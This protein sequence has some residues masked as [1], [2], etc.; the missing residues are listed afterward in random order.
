MKYR[1]TIICIF[2]LIC[3]GHVDVFTQ[4]PYDAIH[5]DVKEE[6]I[7]NRRFKHSLVEKLIK[8]LP[9]DRFTV[10]SLGSSI[11]GKTIYQVKVGE[12]PIKV[13]LWSQMHGNEPT[14]T[15]ALF[16]IFNYLADSSLWL[17]QDKDLLNK[18]TLYF[19]PMLNPDGAD[20]FERR[21]ALPVDLNRDALRLQ[22]PE[23]RI[24]K[25]ANDR[26]DPM[27]GFNL[28][29]QNRYTSAGK[30]GNT[31]SM[32]FLAPAEDEEQSWGERRTA[33][34]Q[35]IVAIN[36][37]LQYYLPNQVGRYSAEFEPR[38]FGDN[39]QKW[40]TGTILIETGGLRGDLEKQQLRK[41][42]FIALMTAFQRM[43]ANSYQENVLEEYDAIPLNSRRLHELVLRNA[44]FSLGENDFTIDV[45]FRNFEIE[46]SDTFYTKSTIADIGDLHN[47]Y[48][49]EEVDASDLT[50]SFGEID[51]TG[52]EEGT[53]LSDIDVVAKIKQGITYLRLDHAPTLEERLQTTLHLLGPDQAPPN[54]L[55]LGDSPALLLKSGKEIKGAIINGRYVTL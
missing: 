6:H 19:I 8:T 10:D 36:K 5:S 52:V 14:A 9:T 49:Y 39:I 38:A 18:L 30:T 11:E 44:T 12:G 32:S 50:I 7:K 2:F 46:M 29:D 25:N 42:N 31:A 16:D 55:D 24:L 51:S 22:N 15:M 34:M 54:Y 26:I 45:G 37:T 3:F 20:R 48:G 43:R 1:S 40:G 23:S 21:N 53:S 47:Y 17:T 33:A 27:W 35:M 13:L 4:S 28:H 41:Y